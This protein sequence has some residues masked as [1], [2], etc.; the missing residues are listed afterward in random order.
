VE[1]TKRSADSRGNLEQRRAVAALASRA[2]GE[3]A[4]QAMQVALKEAGGL[5]DFFRSL[6][7][8]AIIH[9]RFPGGSG[10]GV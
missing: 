9:L 10:V 2:A 5:E 3:Q 6:R 4:A 1:A 8:F 7:D